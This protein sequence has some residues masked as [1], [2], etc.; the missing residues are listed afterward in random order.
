L[1]LLR[2]LGLLGLLGLLELVGLL[3][4]LGLLE[5]VELVGLLGLQATDSC[6]VIA[7]KGLFEDNSVIRTSVSS[8]LSRS[9]SGCSSR[10]I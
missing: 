2:L 3:G 8:I 6:S 1:G 9:G 4:L 5:L 7:I 10:N